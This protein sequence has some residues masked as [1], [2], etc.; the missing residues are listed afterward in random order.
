MNE[1]KTLQECF[2]EN[3]STFPFVIEHKTG[4]YTFLDRLI[5][6]RD[7]SNYDSAILWKTARLTYWAQ[8]PYQT[9][10]AHYKKFKLAKP[11]EF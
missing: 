11:E 1:W 6:Q 8:Y 3:G 7:N 10:L 2:E 9:A 4:S 5:L